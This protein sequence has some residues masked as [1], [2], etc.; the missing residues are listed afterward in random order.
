GGPDAAGPPTVLRA[1][2][3]ADDAARVG[4]DRG[5]GRSTCD[6]HRREHPAAGARGA[7]ADPDS[8]TGLP[9]RIPFFYGWVIVAVGFV[10]MAVWGSART[11][12]LL[13]FSPLLAA[14]R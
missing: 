2:Q 9:L 7:T 10:T 3:R 13:L 5:Y 4:L 12:V 14:C 6:A 8:L 1:F 11:A